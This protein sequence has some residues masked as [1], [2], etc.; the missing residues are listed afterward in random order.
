LEPVGLTGDGKMPDEFTS[1]P[2]YGGLTLVWDATVVD[3]F[4]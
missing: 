1:G 2:R 4:S 3:T